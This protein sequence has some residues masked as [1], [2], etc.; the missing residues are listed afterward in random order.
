[1]LGIGP[2]VTLVILDCWQG[3]STVVNYKCC[4]RPTASQRTFPLDREGAIVGCELGMLSI[5]NIYHFSF[6]ITLYQYFTQP[7][8]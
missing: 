2:S 1:M 3:L 4:Q 5:S 6:T 8:L 7:A